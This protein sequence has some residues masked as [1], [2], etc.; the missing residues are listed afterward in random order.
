[1]MTSDMR[2]RL[3]YSVLALLA[4]TVGAIGYLAISEKAGAREQTELAPDPSATR[5]AIVQVYAA[6]AARWRGYFGVHT[7]IAVKRTDADEFTVHEIMGFRLRRTGTALVARNRDPDALW[8]GS[9]PQLLCVG[10]PANR[11]VRY[12]R[13]RGSNGRKAS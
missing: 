2:T 6:R 8:Y 1:M 12:C 5:D 9:E 4:Y 13:A 11:S 10:A 7:W 3:K